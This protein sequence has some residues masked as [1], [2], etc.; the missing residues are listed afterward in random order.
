MFSFL[1]RYPYLVFKVSKQTPSQLLRSFLI[2]YTK[3]PLSKNPKLPP[4]PYYLHSTTHRSSWPKGLI[5]YGL[6]TQ[7]QFLLGLLIPQSPI[8]IKQWFQFLR[9]WPK[10]SLNK[11]AWNHLFKSSRNQKQTEW[12]NQY[13]NNN[14]LNYGPNFTS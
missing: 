2:S 3:I 12:T 6:T 4:Y 7:V 14:E 1:P 13:N 9:N 8:K 11:E 5:W 10:L